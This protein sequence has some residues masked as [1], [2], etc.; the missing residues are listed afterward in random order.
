MDATERALGEWRS[1]LGATLMF[2]GVYDGRTVLITGHTGFKGA[3]LAVWL[4]RL[5]AQVVGYALRPPTDPSIF[6]SARLADHLQHVE[7]D[8]RNGP[9]LASV[10]RRHRPD[11]IFHLAAAPLVR[12]SYAAP[13]DTFDVNVMGTLAL[14]DA[15]R[16][17]GHPC[18]IVVVST[19][20][21]YENREWEFGYRETDP[22]GGHDPYSASKAAMEIAVGSF[23]RSFFPSE[24]LREHGVRLA[25][26]RA[27]NVIG[28][29]DWSNDRILPDAIRALCRAEPL[30]VRNPC[31]IRPW[32]HVLEPLSG[33][34]WLGASLTA[35]G[36]ERLASG[37]NFG[38]LLESRAVA[39]LADAV[40]A[41]WGSGSWVAETEE[42]APHEAGVLRLSIDKVQAH[43]GWRPVWTFGTTVART[44]A[45]YQHFYGAPA[46]SDAV[47]GACTRDIVAYEAAARSQGLLWAVP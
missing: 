13:T 30:K 37:W 23:R 42:G 1:S 40:I 17:V 32:Q 6:A 43:L 8:I 26:A 45:W 11:F 35:P 9:Y 14:L 18:T 29:G 4:E 20:K 28:G 24:R 7:G 21:C 12:E 47:Y 31:A 16:Q 25:T 44:I 5:G 2:A 41:A 38:P 10:L 33:Y 3:W 27:G 34:L 36:G 15:V 19:D 22:L 39:E 46:E